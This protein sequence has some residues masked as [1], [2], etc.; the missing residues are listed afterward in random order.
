MESVPTTAAPQRSEP[1]AIADD[2]EAI[3]VLEARETS[4]MTS[5][6]V[7]TYAEREGR[8]RSSRVLA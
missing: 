8:P 3:P 7:L 6:L 4:G 5:R 2:V 1:D